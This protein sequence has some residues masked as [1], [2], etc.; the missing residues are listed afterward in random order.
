L[1]SG[2]DVHSATIVIAAF[3][4]GLGL[5]SLAGGS[6]ADRVSR[7]ASVALFAAAELAVGLF[8]L[9]STTL[10]YGVLYE[11]V[12]Q[13]GLGTTSTAAVLFAALLWPT[14]FMGISLPLLARAVT[15]SLDQAASVLGW[16]YGINTLGAAAGAVCATWVLLPRAGLDGSL[17]IAAVL[18]LACAAVAFSIVVDTR[19][20]QSLSPIASPSVGPPTGDGAAFSSEAGDR[21]GFSLPTWTA[22]TALSGFLSLSLEIIWFRLLGVMMKSTAFTFGTLLGIYLAGLGI[23]AAVGGS[24]A[25]RVRRPARWLLAL[26]AGIVVYATLSVTLLVF[27]LSRWHLLEWYSGYFRAYDALNVRGLLADTQPAGSASGITHLAWQFVRVYLLPPAVL[28]LPPTIM[29]G[30]SVPLLQRLVQTELTRLGRR[31]GVVVAANIFGST[32]GV[33]LTGWTLL[34]RIGTSGTLRL[35]LLGS[36]AFVMLAARRERLLATPRR[37]M[38]TCVGVGLVGGALASAVPSADTLWARLHGAESRDVIVGEDRSG[39]SVLRAET[40]HF[41][42]AVLFV[43]GRGHSWIPYGGIHTVLGALPA[44]VHPHPRSAALIGLGS[45]DS[46]FAMASRPSLER[47]VSV[48]I[49]KPQLDMLRRLVGVRGY[50]GID[51]TLRDPRIEHVFGDGRLYIRQAR[52]KYDIIEADALPP[53]SAWSGNLYSDAYFTLLRDHLNRGGLAVSWIPTERAARTF[54]ASFPYVWE[55]PPF[56]VGSNEPIVVD[57]TRVLER[58]NDP[59]LVA[60]FRSADIDIQELLGAYLAGDGTIYD[61]A[62]TSRQPMDLNTDLYPKDEFDIARMLSRAITVWR[63][64]T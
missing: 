47:I 57:R 60:R 58:L 15:R 21:R 8:G 61:P 1:F 30:L 16:L 31:V 18:N 32:L 44:L 42:R 17:R 46:L 64:A 29:A 63:R 12:G 13:F 49:V 20:Q 34:D 33:F 11:R 23:G 37:A 54:L 26:Q 62:R 48:E 27:G 53:N 36:A 4:A 50:P 59:A 55:H 7:T 14:F 10:F 38:S 39:V 51:R 19:R 3:M 28:V 35:L 40:A 45:G 52:Q 2:T 22:V 6:I 9:G 43:N 41:E 56:M 24:I 5:G 25:T